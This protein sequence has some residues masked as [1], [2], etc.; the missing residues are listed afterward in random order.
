[1]NLS[2][3]QSHSFR[4]YLACIAIALHG[5]WIQR[6]VVAWLAWDV[7]G[8]PAFVGF[9]T[10]LSFV[11]T[12]ITGPFFGVIADRIEIRIA[13]FSNYIA[14]LLVTLTFILS[15]Y[16]FG[17]NKISVVF[18]STVIGI[19]ASANHPFRMS[20]AAR[21]GYKEQLSSIIA[22]TTLNFNISRL[23][24]PAIGGVLLAQF[25]PIQTLWVTCIGF[26]PIIFLVRN[27]KIRPRDFSAKSHQQFLSALRD[28]LSYTKKDRFM[29][30]IFGLTVCVTMVGRGLLET[31]PIIAQGLFDKGPNE[32]GFLTASAGGGAIFASFAKAAGKPQQAGKVGFLGIASSILV[33]ISVISLGFSRDILATAG[34]IAL[35]GF[36]ATFFA[37]T[38]QSA[39]QLQLTDEFRGRVMS[40]WTMIAMGGGA[41]GALTL[42][43][44]SEILGIS[45]T[46]IVLGGIT[47]I[48]TIFILLFARSG[49]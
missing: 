21:L 37:T 14:M 24:G 40:L 49:G 46:L 16:V 15:A 32:L 20:I 4:H 3:F 12:M 34:L 23:I 30:Y 19:T 8:S 28:G 39:A 31:L 1:M 41:I 11:P 6:I 42:G 5:V 33:P 27:I 10:F 45:V 44:V 17:I 18:F 35:L 9:A 38:M 48:I 22:I 26:L 7:S 29:L 25:G 13:I 36:S 43:V 2:A 47:I